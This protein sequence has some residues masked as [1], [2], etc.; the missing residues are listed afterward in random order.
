MAKTRSSFIRMR[1]SLKLTKKGLIMMDDGG[2]TIHTSEGPQKRQTWVAVLIPPDQAEQSI[3]QMEGLVSEIHA[4]F[5][6]RELHANE[7]FQRKGP[8]ADVPIGTLKGVVAAV[9]EIFRMMDFPIIVQT[10]WRGNESYEK[11]VRETSDAQIKL[12]KR[13]LGIDF[14]SPKDLAFTYCIHRCRNFLEGGYHASD[15]EI[16]ADAGMMRPGQ[17]TRAPVRWGDSNFKTVHFEDSEI[18]PLVQ[19]ADYAAYFMNRSQQIAHSDTLS[20][21]DEELLDILGAKLNFVNIPLHRRPRQ[22]PI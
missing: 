2:S 18:C 8:W 6:A 17:T 9:A 4:R 22:H 10:F 14:R 19:L 1:D 13:E 12:M 11:I 16:F 5:G 20:V 7:I 3:D 15:W 21:H